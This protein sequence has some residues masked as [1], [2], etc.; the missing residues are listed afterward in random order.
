LRIYEREKRGLHLNFSIFLR[1]GTKKPMRL[2]L[3]VN[4]DSRVE[5]TK[6]GPFGSKLFDSA[7]SVSSG[8][9]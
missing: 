4:Q 5:K 7:V 3:T 6:A 9:M 8:S 1:S 2:E